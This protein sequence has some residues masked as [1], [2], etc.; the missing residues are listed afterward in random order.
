[1]AIVNLI[2]LKPKFAGGNMAVNGVGIPTYGSGSKVLFN[3]PNAD[4]LK[5]SN[6]GL[7]GSVLAPYAHLSGTGGS[8]NG[9][10]IIGG[11]VTQV[12]V[13]EFHNFKFT[14]EIPEILLPIKL[15]S[16]QVYKTGQDVELKWQTVSEVNGSHFE[17]ERSSNVLDW[18]QIGK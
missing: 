12:D 11:N 3:F 15:S 6:F 10:A 8:I 7:L 9:Q 4:S 18:V 16:F 2:D 1:T 5:L 14:R 13:F 17:I